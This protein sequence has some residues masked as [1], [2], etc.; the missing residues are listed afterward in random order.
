[1]DIEDA[2]R[3]RALDNLLTRPGRIVGPGFEPCP[4]IREFLRDDCR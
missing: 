4:E 3:W 2:G 1:M